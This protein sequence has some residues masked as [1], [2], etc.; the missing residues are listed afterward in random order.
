MTETALMGKRVSRTDSIDRS[1]IEWTPEG[2][3]LDSPV[4]TSLGVFE[5]EEKDGS[6]RK[7]LRLAEHICSL[8]SLQSYL[9]KPIILTHKAGRVNKN[10]VDDVI[11]GTILSKG[12]R[13]G[14]DVRA[15]IIIHDIDELKRSGLRQLSLGYDLTI[16]DESG[17]HDEY[18]PYDC[19]QS[20]IVVNHLAVVEDAR[21]GDQARL[22]LD[23]KKSEVNND[24]SN[25]RKGANEMAKSKSI[26]EKYKARRQRRL[27][28]DSP[29]DEILEEADELL[30]EDLPVEDEEDEEATAP[31]G[32]ID[33]K[34]RFVKDRRTRRDEEGEVETPDDA[35]LRI[36]Q[37]DEDVDTL[38]DIVDELQARLDIL[39]SEKSAK[40][41]PVEQED[42]EDEPEEEDVVALDDDIEP[43]SPSV[44]VGSEG[45]PTITIKMDSVDKVVKERLKL[46][47]IGDKLNMDGLEDMN[48]ITAKK[49][50][51]NRVLPEMR[52][53]GKGKAYLN[54]AYDIALTRIDTMEKRSTDYQ[55]RQAV[56]RADSANDTKPSAESARERMIAK[57]T[58]GK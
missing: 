54:A 14:E 3:L 29:E 56:A 10:N 47:R 2:Y 32:S 57:M 37:Y 41:E 21:A 40:P 9:G 55:R 45:S 31:D 44:S 19:I 27:D 30:E 34:L 35:E 28:G 52:L 1:R 23:G 8:D 42:E 11:I 36:A 15:K 43:A 51:I 5:Y 4:V 49:A 12:Y 25:G 13:D 50:I 46:A 7:E 58:G 33:D 48:P 22:N 17:I 16:I 53:D 18:G 6:I 38:L 20:N 39:E 24:M 26:I